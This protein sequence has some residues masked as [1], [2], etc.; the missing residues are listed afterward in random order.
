MSGADKAK[1]KPK[2]KSETK[3]AKDAKGAQEKQQQQLPDKLYYIGVWK[4]T[5]KDFEGTVE[6]VHNRAKRCAKVQFIVLK[7]KAVPSIFL[8][9][10]KVLKMQDSNKSHD[11]KQDPYQFPKLKGNILGVDVTFSLDESLTMFSPKLSGTYKSRGTL[12]DDDGKFT[13]TKTEK[14]SK[15]FKESSNC[16]IM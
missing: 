4:S 7:G 5:I 1:L 8:P 9:L 3:D 14:I 15:E 16:S 2:A 11:A 12:I 10:R 13:V 6:V